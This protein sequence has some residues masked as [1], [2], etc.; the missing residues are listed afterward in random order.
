M[1]PTRSFP[2]AEIR[3]LEELRLTALQA[4]VEADLLLGR[5]A[6]VVS[7]LEGLSWRSAVPVWANAAVRV[8]W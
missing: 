5:Q 2:Q 6:A 3:R 8:G 1:S 4:R 7:E